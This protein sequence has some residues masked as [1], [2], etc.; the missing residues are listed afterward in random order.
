MRD[1]QENLSIGASDLPQ[2]NENKRAAA[3]GTVSR[4]AAANAMS[5]RELWLK[6]LECESVLSLLNKLDVIRA[7]PSR[8][9]HLIRPPCRIGAAVLCLSQALATMFSDDVAQVSY[10]T[11]CCHA[12]MPGMS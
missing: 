11:V 6:K 7:A 4:E 9:D 2:P 12:V 5:L 3:K 1:I 10:A 8:F